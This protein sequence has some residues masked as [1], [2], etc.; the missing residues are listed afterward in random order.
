M[1]MC[2]VVMTTGEMIVVLGE[3]MMLMMLMITA[4]KGCVTESEHDSEE[5]PSRRKH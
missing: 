4:G 2:V 5:D 3:V 1:R